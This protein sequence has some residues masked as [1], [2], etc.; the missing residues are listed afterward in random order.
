LPTSSPR[1]SAVDLT[2]PSRM[3]SGDPHSIPCARLIRF[4]TIP[5]VLHLMIPPRHSDLRAT[6]L[7]ADDSRPKHSGARHFSRDARMAFCVL[8][9]TPSSLPT[10]AYRWTQ[11][12][13]LTTK[14]HPSSVCP[15]FLASRCALRMSPLQL[16][17]FDGLSGPVIPPY[18]SH[19]PSLV[20]NPL[21]TSALCKPTLLIWTP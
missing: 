1:Y 20:S 9:G 18:V 12:A 17:R 11:Q 4:P 6:T 19:P 2:P 21:M 14:F 13:E 16:P 5:P 3:I 10:L 8:T 7:S 15:S